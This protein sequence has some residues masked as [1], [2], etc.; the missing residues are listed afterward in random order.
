MISV[1]GAGVVVA[2]SRENVNKVGPGKQHAHENAA[3]E[4]EPG[5][6][7]GCGFNASPP[8]AMTDAWKWPLAGPFTT[9]IVTKV[10]RTAY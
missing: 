8:A 10:L 7:D 4:A 9:Y 6:V 1:I 5:N 3:H 2:K